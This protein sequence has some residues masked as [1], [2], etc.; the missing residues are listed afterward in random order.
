MC[1]APPGGSKTHVLHMKHRLLCHFSGAFGSTLAD[2]RPTAISFLNHILQKTYQ[3]HLIETW[4][5]QSL[6]SMRGG[7]YRLTTRG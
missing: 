4:N 7:A 3:F 2:R 5:W 6:R 1:G